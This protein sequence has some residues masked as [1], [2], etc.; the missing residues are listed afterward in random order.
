MRK[1]AVTSSAARP[2]PAVRWAAALVGVVL[3]MTVASKIAIPLPGTP[4][5]FT[6][7]VLGVLL[8]GAL[9][10]PA[11]AASGQALFLLVGLAG[12]PVFAL[13]G[14]PAYLVGPTG[15]Y[16]LAYPLAA[17]IAGLGGAQ[18]R[19]QL[20]A[21]LAALATI[22]LGG[23]SWLARA[24]PERAAAWAV[25]PFLGPDLVKVAV[26]WLVAHRAAGPARRWL[27]GD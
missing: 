1:F 4:V 23:W 9:L 25:W 10:G 12:A 18:G 2:V 22:Y 26:A 17:A 19:R 14:G 21:F 3:G 6:F 24:A 7:Q 16:L 5:P 20:L 13:G 8:S 15:G 27:Q 11:L